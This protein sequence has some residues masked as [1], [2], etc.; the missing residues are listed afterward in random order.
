MKKKLAYLVGV[1][2]LF[3]VVCA[4]TLYNFTSISSVYQSPSY[5]SSPLTVIF[6]VVDTY[7][8]WWKVRTTNLSGSTITGYMTDSYIQFAGAT[9]T[10]GVVTNTAC[11]LR[12][13][14]GTRT[15]PL[16]TVYQGMYLTMVTNVVEWYKITNI[17]VTNTGTNR[18]NTNYGWVYRAAS[19]LVK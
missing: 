18:V 10:N 11:Y 16:A 2:T 17:G 7:G 4:A 8:Q 15:R 19:P 13:S 3:A 9:F 12:R 14:P 5:S 1:I 6:S